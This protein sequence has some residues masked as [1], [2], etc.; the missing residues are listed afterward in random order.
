VARH[1]IRSMNANS[2]FQSTLLCYEFRIYMDRGGVCSL[3][4]SR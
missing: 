4:R 2:D 1:K 3:E